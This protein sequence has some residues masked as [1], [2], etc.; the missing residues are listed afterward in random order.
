MKICF[1][2][3]FTRPRISRFLRLFLL[4]HFLKVHF[5]NNLDCLGE[6][7]LSARDENDKE[8]KFEYPSLLFRR[9]KDLSVL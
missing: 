2:G 3:G 1:L 6:C 5:F 9:G 8:R 7:C 4:I